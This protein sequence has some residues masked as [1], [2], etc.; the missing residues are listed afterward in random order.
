[1]YD[2]AV[3]SFEGFDVLATIRFR[4]ESIGEYAWP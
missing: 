4:R 2:Y 1:M 3:V